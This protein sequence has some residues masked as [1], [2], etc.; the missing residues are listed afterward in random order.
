MNRVQ[1]S[2]V[3]QPPQV[4][5][6]VGLDGHVS[7]RVSHERCH[8]YAAIGGD[9]A[10]GPIGIRHD[11]ACGPF[12][13][14]QCQRLERGPLHER[15]AVA[16]CPRRQTAAIHHRARRAA[17]NGG[18][19]DHGRGRRGFYGLG[20]MVDAFFPGAALM[21][22]VFC[23]NLLGDGLRDIVDPSRRT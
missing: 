5:G 14:I 10:T 1:L 20:R 8:L 2:A 15:T 23:F 9:K 12:R 17:A 19:G 7:P 6:R 16:R 11:F 3:V 22:A 13:S 21:L 18:V 4:G